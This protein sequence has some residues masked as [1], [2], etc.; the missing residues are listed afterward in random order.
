MRARAQPPEL[1][2][3]GPDERTLAAQLHAVA[4]HLPRQRHHVSADVPM[5]QYPQLPATV[6]SIL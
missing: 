2:R 4:E 3:S 5:W 6:S 1:V